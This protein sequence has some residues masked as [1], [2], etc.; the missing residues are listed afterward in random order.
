MA[1]A[2]VGACVAVAVLWV[3]QPPPSRAIVGPPAA[4][5]VHAPPQTDGAPDAAPTVDA[6]TS[7]NGAPADPPAAT[8]ATTGPLTASEPALRIEAEPDTLRVW[9]NTRVRLRV[10]LRQGQPPYDDYVWHFEDGSDPVRGAAVDHTFA[11]SVRDRHVTVEALRAGQAPAVVSRNLPV[12]RLA[13]AALDGEEPA[14]SPPHTGRGVRALFAM[15]VP[16]NETVA[17]VARAAGAFQVAAVVA[18]GDDVAMSA[19]ADALAQAAPKA[20]LFRL[21]PDGDA[22]PWLARAADP[23]HAWSEVQVG[24]RST[25]VWSSGDVAIVPM[26]TRPEVLAEPAIGHMRAA[27]AAAAAY[28]HVVVVAAR[29]LTPLRDGELASDRAYR[30][31]EYALRYQA[32]LVVSVGSEVF[33]DGR[34]GGVGVASVGR[35]TAHDC[36]RLLGSEPC[37]PASATVIEVGDKRRWRAWHLLEPDFGRAVPEADFPREAGKVRR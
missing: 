14:T 9:T 32:T 5:A 7:T 21:Q 28:A 10:H 23:A 1:S 8:T 16:A 19:L 26:D 4:P 22:Q 35:T 30:L 20:A 31:Y 34:F 13:P 18:S 37:Q 15:Q 17:A 29:P 33:Y 24:Y 36:A 3:G 25:G 6:V 2:A 12:E 27:L 11:E